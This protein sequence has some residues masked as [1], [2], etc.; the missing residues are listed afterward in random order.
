MTIKVNDPAHPHLPDEKSVT[1]GGDYGDRVYLHP[2]AAGIDGRVADEVMV[3]VGQLDEEGFPNG[4]NDDWGAS[5]VDRED[6]VEAVL[7]VFPEL[8]RASNG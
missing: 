2:W 5:L 7:A 6:F 1:V 4:D 3:T 8:V